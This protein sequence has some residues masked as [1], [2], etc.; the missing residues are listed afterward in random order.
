M[1][2]KRRGAGRHPSIYVDPSETGEP[3]E[4]PPVAE[5]DG[6]FGPGEGADHGGASR[7]RDPPG[8]LG[9]DEPLAAHDALATRLD[10]DTLGDHETFGVL[11]AH[12]AQAA[13]GDVDREPTPDG[14]S[15][16]GDLWRE[17]AEEDRV[18]LRDHPSASHAAEPAARGSAYRMAARDG[19]P[20]EA[21]QLSATQALDGVRPAAAAAGRDE[22]IAP[23]L[24]PPDLPAAM[25]AYGEAMLVFAR[26]PEW[27]DARL[28]DAHAVLAPA[29]RLNQLVI[30]KAPSSADGGA[31]A[32]VGVAV[33]AKV[34]RL[35]DRKLRRLAKTGLRPQLE[36]DE[37]RSGQTPWLIALAGAPQ[38][39]DATQRKLADLLGRPA[40][41]ESFERPRL[42]DGSRHEV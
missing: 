42:T 33:W 12:G 25:R 13:Q 32:P 40:Y 1:F 10:H 37:W 2:S 23:P 3:N 39:R 15:F 31:P 14:A 30:A 35:V 11:R 28:A 7:D 34:D 29:A 38:V 18:R 24:A 8:A 16:E 27:A 17:D 9:V 6:G 26:D 22:T 41:I 4:V 19:V 36:D 5:H 20:G 21:L